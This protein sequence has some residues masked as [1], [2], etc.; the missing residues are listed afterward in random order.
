MTYQESK[1]S[2]SEQEFDSVCRQF[3]VM[4]EAR[5]FVKPMSIR[6]E[7]LT[8]YFTIVFD[9]ALRP[10]ELF[11]PR[12]QDFDLE[13]LILTLPVTKTGFKPCPCSTWKKPKDGKKK[14]LVKVNKKC[15]DCKGIG[16]LRKVQYTTILRKDAEKLRVYFKEQGL[17]PGDIPFPFYQQILRKYFKEAGQL[18]GLKIFT[19]KESRMIYNLYPYILRESR[20][21]IMEDMGAKSSIVSAKL[22]HSRGSNLLLRYQWQD[23]NAVKTWE[24]ANYK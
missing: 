4:Y 6:P 17:G 15:E 12:V 21:K 20:S 14:V 16:K 24:L 11:Y 18:A 10:K 22:R 3:Y 13:N 9:C 5:K 19:A 2:I 7:V 1:N 23:L 8:M